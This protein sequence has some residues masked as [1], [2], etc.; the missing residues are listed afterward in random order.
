M[1]DRVLPRRLDNDYRGHRLALMIAGLAL[2]LWR[3]ADAPA[4]A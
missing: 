1:R 4:Q 2:S 3:R